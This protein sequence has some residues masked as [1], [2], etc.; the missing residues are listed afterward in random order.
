MIAGYMTH[1]FDTAL[2]ELEKAYE[3][4][5]ALADSDSQ[6]LEFADGLDRRIH[7]LEEFA[8][9][10]RVYVE[11]VR[12]D[13]RKSFRVRPRIRQV[14]NLL[15]GYAK[16]R[17]VEIEIGAA[18]DLKAP[19]IPATLYNGIL[20]NLFTNAL[21]AVT[22]KRGGDKRRIAFRAWNDSRWHYLQVSDN[23]VG[24]PD[25]LKERVFDPLFSTTELNS[26]SLGS[27]MGLGLSLIKRGAE[28][29]GGR[30]DLVLPPPEF[31]TCVEVRL[32]QPRS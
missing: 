29:F 17:N 9:Y 19:P 2:Y 4:L 18:K 32:P 24:I 7:K 16:E 28:S 21:K 10:A 30:V 25:P 27:G 5:R 23:G 3:Q 22:A 14:M 1:E 31:S 15:G 6:F 12:R 13:V 11:G 8:Q 20:Q 26:D